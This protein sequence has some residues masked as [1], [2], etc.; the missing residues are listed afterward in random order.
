MAHLTCYHCHITCVSRITN[1][2]LYRWSRPRT[3]PVVAGVAFNATTSDRILLNPFRSK[4]AL[5]PCG[6]R[7]GGQFES[8]SYPL[9]INTRIAREICSNFELFFYPP[10]SHTSHPLTPIPSTDFHPEFVNNK[11][12]LTGGWPHSVTPTTIPSIFP[13]PS[14]ITKSEPTPEARDPAIFCLTSSGTVSGTRNFFACRE[15]LAGCWGA[16]LTRMF[17]VPTVWREYKH[18]SCPDFFA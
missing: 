17:G 3:M 5:K 12:R 18:V 7:A 2:N 6:T 4:C 15:A 11:N 1:S 9:S 13:V 10:K 16:A 14:S 8:Q